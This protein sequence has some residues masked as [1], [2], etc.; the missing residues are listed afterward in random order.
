MSEAAHLFV[1]G[2]VNAMEAEFQSLS[3]RLG[4]PTDRVRSIP[5]P[6]S[7]I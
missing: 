3:D 7:A 1:M 4:F 2:P 6:S 5:A